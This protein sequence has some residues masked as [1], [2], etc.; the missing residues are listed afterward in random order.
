M[1]RI[2]CL[3]I[4][5]F[6]FLN[7][8]TAQFGIDYN[9]MN[10]GNYWI[11][12]IDSINGEYEPATFRMDVECIELIGDQEFFRLKQ[13]QRRDDG[14]GNPS[15]WYI[16]T[17]WNSIGGL[18]GAF[19][20]G[21][22]VDSAYVYNPP[23]LSHP[24]EATT[25]GYTWEYDFPGTGI[26]IQHWACTLESF[27]ETVE[28]PAGVFYDC[29]KMSMIITDAQGDTSQITNYYYAAGVGQVLNE[30]WSFW[31][32][33]YSYELIEY[34]LE[35]PVEYRLSPNIP[36]QYLLL[37]NHPNP[38]NPTTTIS[39]SLPEQSKITLT[40]FD[41]RGTEVMN[42]QEGTKSPGY[43]RVQWSCVDRS[44]NPVGTGVYF[45]RLQS[46][47]PL[48]DGVHYSQTIKMVYLR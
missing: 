48:S 31:A 18:I 6:L 37:Q 9:S 29:M 13:E 22:G 42:L 44:G 1:K 47:A 5:S 7:F 46:G 16:W 35:S 11:Q 32:G 15:C 24:I 3:L 23:L 12:H 10:V 4:T 41:I 33:H 40:I 43:H 2:A 14:S 20:T 39:Y 38:F 30:G 25:P 8:L 21:P 26:G 17:G 28:V 45:A 19:G 34:H 27:S 36:S